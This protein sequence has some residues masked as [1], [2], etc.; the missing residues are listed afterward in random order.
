MTPVH[1]CERKKRCG[2]EKIEEGGRDRKSARRGGFIDPFCG[3][4]REVFIFVSLR[5][6]SWLRSTT[7]T[8]AL[9][10]RRISMSFRPMRFR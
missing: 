8:H 5:G 4:G 10:I 1:L 6:F 7:Y 3:I 9:S 2:F